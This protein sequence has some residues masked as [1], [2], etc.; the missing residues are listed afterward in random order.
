MKKNTI[1]I[2]LV[3]FAAAYQWSCMQE[4]I[5]P[6]DDNITLRKRGGNGNGN[7]GGDGGGNV[8]IYRVEYHGALAGVAYGP[9]TRDNKKT[10]VIGAGECTPFV[11][12][13]IPDLVGGC[14]DDPLSNVWGP[15]VRL[16]DRRA[17][18]QSIRIAVHLFISYNGSNHWLRFFGS[19]CCDASCGSVG[20]GTSI[21]PGTS[22]T[23]W[24]DLDRMVVENTEGGCDTDRALS[25]SEVVRVKIS[26]EDSNWSCP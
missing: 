8:P 13:G 26:L 22:E 1:V 3:L 6:T 17:E 25:S 23:V 2:M 15:S 9:A 11:I 5:T 14:F 7:G 24:V 12:T 19:I 18:E 16:I 20:C 4:T 21:L 10:Q